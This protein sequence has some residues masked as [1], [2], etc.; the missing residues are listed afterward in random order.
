MSSPFQR[1]FSSKS[2]LNEHKKIQRQINMLRKNPERAE[3]KGLSSEGQGGIDFEKI[4]QLEAK[5]ADA[6]EAHNK[7]RTEE[8]SSQVREDE[9]AAQGSA[10]EM[11]SPLNGSYTSPAGEPYVSHVGMIQQA[12]GA[13][14]GALD[15]YM[16]ESEANKAKRLSARAQGRM[17]R[18]DHSGVQKYEKDGKLVELKES[19][20]YDNIKTATED[21][22]KAFADAKANASFYNQ[23]DV[24]ID[25]IMN[26]T[27]DIQNR[28][29][30]AGQNA[31]A[32]AT[33]EK[34]AEIEELKK[35]IELLKK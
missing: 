33:A 3:R 29:I 11:R 7:N 5:L 20:F 24:N 1:A 6:K 27:A 4:S 26:K 14:Q 23:D 8:E 32:Q 16:N 17:N 13:I 19:D 9:D 2:P 25:H 35:K 10:A 18:L 21:Q 12:A 15:S 22:K 28:A 34:D 31:T 30:T